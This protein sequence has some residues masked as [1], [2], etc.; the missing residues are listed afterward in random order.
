ME[1]L[2]VESIGQFT[3]QGLDLSKYTIYNLAVI[4]FLCDNYGDIL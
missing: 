3:H 1:K 2:Q 4:G